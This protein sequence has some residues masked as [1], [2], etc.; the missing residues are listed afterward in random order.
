MIEVPGPGTLNKGD[1]RGKLTIGWSGEWFMF[2]GASRHQVLKLQV[3]GVDLRQ[4]SRVRNCNPEGIAGLLSLL[5]EEQIPIT[6]LE[7]GQDSVPI[8]LYQPFLNDADQQIL[9]ELADFHQA[10]PSQTG[11]APR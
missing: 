2:P 1:A 8:I 11:V 3:G 9:Q 5:E 4:F 7:I 10:Q 6:R